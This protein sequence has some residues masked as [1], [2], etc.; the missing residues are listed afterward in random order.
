MALALVL[1]S[2]VSIPTLRAAAKE[3][4]PQRTYPLLN[5]VEID[6]QQSLCQVIKQVVEP[7]SW[8]EKG[9]D[10]V[11]MVE[12]LTQQLLVKQ[13]PAVHKKI[14]KLLNTMRKMKAQK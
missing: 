4:L 5:L 12:P 1:V 13:S 7:S 2:L 14:E 10:G 3:V 8:Q 6:S 11:L 9:G